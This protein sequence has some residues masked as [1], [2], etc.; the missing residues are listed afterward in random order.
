MILDLS[1]LESGH[2]VRVDWGRLKFRHMLLLLATRVS[3]CA[4]HLFLLFL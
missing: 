3:P 1:E 2:L 4:G